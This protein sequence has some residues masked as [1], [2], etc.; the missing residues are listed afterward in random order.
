[1]HLRTAGVGSLFSLEKKWP[2]FADLLQHIPLNLDKAG[3]KLPRVS[4]NGS[5]L[6]A[7]FHTSGGLPD[8]KQASICGCL[9]AAL[10]CI[11]SKV[12]NLPLLMSFVQKSISKK[13]IRSATSCTAAE[14]HQRKYCGFSTLSSSLSSVKCSK[15][16][17]I[18]SRLQKKRRPHR[19]ATLS[20]KA[21]KQRNAKGL[22][23]R[24]EDAELCK[25]SEQRKEFQKYRYEG[26]RQIHSVEGG[27][28][29][30][31]A[32]SLLV[33]DARMQNP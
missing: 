3:L 29:T 28:N 19:I 9:M 6:P 13:P 23:Q 12:S 24:R 26:M 17:S 20:E 31:L 11:F 27:M 10:K 2:C 1:M 32:E 14:F 4:Y 30:E 15:L 5:Y 33:D 8:K 18:C 7:R 22:A 16:T 21:T 25:V